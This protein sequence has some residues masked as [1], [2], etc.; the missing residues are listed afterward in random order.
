[1]LIEKYGEKAKPLLDSLPVIVRSEGENFSIGLTSD[2]IGD[3]IVEKTT[4]AITAMAPDFGQD[5]RIYQVS[6][7]TT[8]EMSSLPIQDASMRN[9]VHVCDR[10][11]FE[12]DFVKISNRAY[13][14]KLY[15][16]YSEASEFWRMCWEIAIPGLDYL[17]FYLFEKYDLKE[18]YAVSFNEEGFIIYNSSDKIVVWG[19]Y[20]IAPKK[21]NILL[22]T[23]DSN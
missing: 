23:K 13:S 2:S 19:T 5:P 20:V 3:C 8:A 16:P 12:A 1:M 7:L 9:W 6:L 22:P 18:T 17:N 10:P 4:D 11:K 14:R 15:N 21:L